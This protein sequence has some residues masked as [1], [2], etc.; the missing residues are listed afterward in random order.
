[1]PKA[2]PDIQRLIDFHRLLLQFQAIERI[3]HVPHEQQAKF[4]WENDT[5]HSYSLTMTAWFLCEY[6]PHLDRDKV[7]R[8][9]LVHDLV[10]VHA[11]D[12]Y[13]FA[14]AE[15]LAS[16]AAREAA[17]L[18]QLKTDWPDFPELV[19]NIHAYE[20]K[21][22]AEAKF[23][24]A[25]DKIMPVLLIFIGKGYTWQTEKI[26][27]EVLDAIKRDKVALSPEIAAYYDEL[28][29]LL[30]KHSHYFAGGGSG[31]KP[32]RAAT[33][34]PGDSENPARPGATRRPKD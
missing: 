21:A 4:R 28:Y 5:E 23:V 1:M 31:A 26:N 11:G 19:E 22:D 33:D 10:E 20:S 12:T 18:Q 8:Y 3:V 30:T 14:D 2:K 29:E 34:R 24:Y 16:K 7:I 15:Q 9:A 13:V 25:L 27:L 6:F 17:A 32:G